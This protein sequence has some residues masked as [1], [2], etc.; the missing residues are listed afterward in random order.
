MIRRARAAWLWLALALLAAQGFGHW[1]RSAHAL[2]QAV[3]A[4]AATPFDDHQPGDAE[5]RLLDQLAQADGLAWAPSP[6]PAAG[7]AP[8]PAAEALRS[9]R[10]APSWRLRAR[11][12]PAG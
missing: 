2:T 8:R 10:L 5:C 4:G 12:P 1:H 9:A 7:E 3:A 6:L 11:G